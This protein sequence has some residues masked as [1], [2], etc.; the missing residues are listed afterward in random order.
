LRNEAANH[1]EFIPMTNDRV[2]RRKR[3]AMHAIF[4]ALIMVSG[5]TA[6]V[7]AREVPKYAEIQPG[8]GS[9]RAPVGHR[10]PTQRDVMEARQAQS[11]KKSIE[12]DNELLGL[13]PSQSHVTGG[14]EVPADE[15]TL[16]KM[17]EQENARIDR[18]VSGI[19]RGC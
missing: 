13:S 18:L 14:D 9:M 15:N 1:L 19:C 3:R 11:D 8:H 5:S 16:T 7:H 4:A 6:V 2:R 17:I 12:Q 10:Q